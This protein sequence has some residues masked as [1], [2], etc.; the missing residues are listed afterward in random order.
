M[1]NFEPI[2]SRRNARIKQ[3]AKIISSSKARREAKLTVVDGV[4][5]ICDYI[6]KFGQPVELYIDETKLERVREVLTLAVHYQLVSSEVMQVISPVKT[7]SGALAVVKIPSETL[8]ETCDQSIILLDQVQDPNNF[9]AICRLA[10]AVGIEH[11]LLSDGSTD[12]YHPSAIR[13]SAGAIFN[14]KIHQKVNL[15]EFIKTHQQ[16]H[17]LV[18]SSHATQNI[19]ELR[20]TKQIGWLF[21]NEGAGV[22]PELLSLANQA[23][24]IPQSVQLESLNLA[25]AVAVCLYEQKRQSLFGKK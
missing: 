24:K 20:L 22:R 16:Y 14:I 7:S 12:A 10:L 8:F 3:V 23:V 25:T 13:A 21:G 17:Y 19:F 6:K 2:R 4:N 15:A 11:V 18:A 5:F 9:G 1:I